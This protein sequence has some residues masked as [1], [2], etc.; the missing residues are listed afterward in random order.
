MNTAMIEISA[1]I[2]Q[3]SG[4]WDD[5]ISSPVIMKLN[6]N[7]LPVSMSTISIEG[8]DIYEVSDYVTDTLIPIFE[9]VDG[10]AQVTASGIVTQ[11]VDITI[12][13]SR[14]DALNNAILRDVDAELADAEEQLRDARS[15]L[16]SGK[17]ELERAR[18]STLAQIDEGLA[19][20]E[21]GSK[22]MPGAIAQL[23]Q[24]RASLQKQLDEAKASLAQMEALVN[25]SDAE[26]AQ[27]QQVAKALSGLEEQRSALQKQLEGIENGS[28]SGNADALRQQLKEAQDERAGLLAEVDSLKDYIEDLQLLDA[29]ALKNTIAALEGSIVAKESELADV[30][31]R[32]EEQM[33]L[34]YMAQQEIKDLDAQL[35]KFETAAPVVSAE[36]TAVAT[37]EVTAEPTAEITAEPTIEATVE[38]TA[39]PA[40]E[41]TMEVA[42]DVTAE[43]APEA[44][45]QPVAFDL[46]KLFDNSAQAETETLS[47]EELLSRRA[48]AQ[49]A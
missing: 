7:M 38:P 12:E 23:E 10:V 21:N 8:A 46:Q 4:D 19:S 27:I 6:P 28:S 5:A 39:E 43:P 37:A 30:R 3:L 41:L 47:R 25:M 49:A 29:D 48:A 32:L 17:S 42:P 33:A 1:E 14:I 35:A 20:I 2:D 13:Q 11:Q 24:Q 26:K 44:S 34:S 31:A 18:K 16:S 45:Q 36:P 15:E 22:Q 40:P 9:G